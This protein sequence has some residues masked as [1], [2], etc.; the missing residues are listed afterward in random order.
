[1]SKFFIFMA[2][3]RLTATPLEWLSLLLTGGWLWL[4]LVL[5]LGVCCCEGG[6]PNPCCP[7]VL[8]PA[9]VRVVIAMRVPPGTCECADGTV[10]DVDSNPTC[11]IPF[12]NEQC[13][14]AISPGSP[15]PPLCGYTFTGRDRLALGCHVS[16][17]SIWEFNWYNTSSGV[18]VI[19]SSIDITQSTQFCPVGVPNSLTG[20]RT[21][22]CSPFLYQLRGAGVCEFFPTFGLL[23]AMGTIDITV[24][25]AP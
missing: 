13:W 10:V 19:G 9:R 5:L 17:G 12:N 15:P 6:V 4:W 14:E 16:A 11:Q 20:G 23:C 21:T 8:L 18:P 24:T 3:S 7:G 2:V 22:R 25:E 1:M